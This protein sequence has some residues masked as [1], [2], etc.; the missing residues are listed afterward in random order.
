MAEGDQLMAVELGHVEH[1]HRR[2]LSE[3]TAS[4]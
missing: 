2:T 3:A 1:F 4:A